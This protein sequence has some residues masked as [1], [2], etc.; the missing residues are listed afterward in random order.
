MMSART[1]LRYALH[2]YQRHSDQLVEQHGECEALCTLRITRTL[3]YEH[4]NLF[5][6]KY[7][8]LDQRWKLFQIAGRQN[9]T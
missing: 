6:T 5:F 3:P 4:V 7:W 8:V 9:P 1:T 2:V